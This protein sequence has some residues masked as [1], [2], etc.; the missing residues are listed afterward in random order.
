MFRLIATCVLLFGSTMAFAVDLSERIDQL[1]QAH[2]GIAFPG[3][4]VLV[5][6]NGEPIHQRGYGMADLENDIVATA[7]TNYRLASLSKAFTSLAI[8]ILVERGLVDYEAPMTHYLDGFSAYGDDIK[9]RHLLHHQSGLKDYESRIPTHWTHQL[10][11]HDVVEILSWQSGTDFAPGS[12]YRYSNAG[13][14]ALAV[15]VSKVSGMSFAEFLHREIFLPLGMLNSVAYEKDISAVS[16]R[17][18]GYTSLDK[19]LFVQTDQNRASAI[20]GDGGVYSSVTD[21]FYWD[22]ALYSLPMISEASRQ[23]IFT[24]GR[25]N[26]GTSTNY[27][28]GWNIEFW[29]DRRRI[30]HTGSTIGFRSVFRRFPDQG[31]SVFIIANQSNVSLCDI[32]D[33]IADMYFEDMK[34][35]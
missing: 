14:S 18:Y 16:N 17:A 30:S 8:V 5:V 22:Q 7:E 2:T 34:V 9:I 27:G 19:G 15:I 33:L 26:D 10:T 20:L 28:F 12:E 11:D 29:Q 31:F 3:A 21:M 32:A 25:L 6:K 1:M 35:D 4:A 23:K 24:P 13:Y